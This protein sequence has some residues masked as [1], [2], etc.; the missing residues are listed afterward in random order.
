MHCLRMSDDHF[1]LVDFFYGVPPGRNE[2]VDIERCSGGRFR[3]IIGFT[4]YL[5]LFYCTDL[6]RKNHWATVNAGAG[7]RSGG[8]QSKKQSEETEGESEKQSGREGQG[9][10]Q[11]D[12]TEGQSK[13]QSGRE[14][15][16]QSDET[17]S[18]SKK[19]SGCEGQRKREVITEKACSCISEKACCR[20]SMEERRGCK[21][22]AFRNIAAM[23]LLKKYNNKLSGC[24]QEITNHCLTLLDP[25]G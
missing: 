8:S 16:K 6:S 18:E 9:K 13:K 19:Q 14:G 10:K 17:E 24:M 25:N 2:G 4:S 3:V 1:K 20:C 7:Q 11:S 15:K 12:E 22:I 5:F 23:R 21:E